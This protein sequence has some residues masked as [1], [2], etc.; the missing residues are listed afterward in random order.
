MRAADFADANENSIEGASTK[1]FF[2]HIGLSYR[3]YMAG[4]DDAAEELDQA[5]VETYGKCVID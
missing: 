3:Y 5:L 4:N 1:I 2:N